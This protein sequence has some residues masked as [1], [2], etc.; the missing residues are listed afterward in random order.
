MEFKALTDIAYYC[1]TKISIDTLDK[2]NYISTENMLPNIGGVTEASSLPKSGKVTEFKKGDVLF[3]NIR[4]YF[5]KVWLATFDGGCSNDVLVFRKKDELI[6]TNFLYYI[7]A[8]DGFINYTVT[9]SKGTKMPRGDKSAIIDYPIEKS[10]SLTQQQKIASILSLLDDKIELNNKMNQMLENM[11][12]SIFKEW[13][14]EFNFPN[15]EGKPYK[16]NHGAMHPSELGEIPEGWEVI[17]LEKIIDKY[18]D[19]RGKT[20]PVKKTGIPL[21]EV[22]NMP[23]DMLLANPKVDKYVTEETYNTWFRNHLEENDILISTVGTIGKTCLVPKNSKI[24]IAQ[25]VLGIRFN[26]ATINTEYIFYQ[27]K[28]KR[29]LHSINA[30]LVTTVQASIKRKDLNTIDVLVPPLHIQKKFSLLVE[31]YIKKQQMLESQTLIKLRDTL[32]PKLMSG[33][34]KV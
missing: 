25:N 12:Q 21:L 23:D 22:R 19:N 8:N 10:F 28:S 29:F 33:E 32:L 4:T 18:I 3:S 6:D 34:I 14:E 2:N 16:A 17:K 7:L 30:R 24:A 20:P 27:M 9:N 13:F 26:K 15:A 1:T 11:A 5:K 31:P